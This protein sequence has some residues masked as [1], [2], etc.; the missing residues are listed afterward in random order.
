[1]ATRN[2]CHIC[3]AMHT[4]KLT[5]LGADTGLIAALRQQQARDDAR[6]EAIRLFTLAVLETMSTLANR[7]IEAPLDEQLKPYAGAWRA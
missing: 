5:A 4:A 3:V 1:M 2:G 6:L 7:M